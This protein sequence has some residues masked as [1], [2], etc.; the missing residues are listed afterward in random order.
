MCSS[1]IAVGPDGYKSMVRCG[2]CL[3]CR[4]RRKQSWVGRLVLERLEHVAARF[5]TLTYA[6]Q[7]QQASALQPAHAKLFLDLYR[8]HYGP[9]RYFLVGE[10]GEKS[11]HAHWHA[12]I[13]GHPQEFGTGLRNGGHW[14]NNKAW[15]RGYSFDGAVTLQSIGY[16]A[17]YT[18][19]EMARGR[20][21]ITR[22]S[23]KPGLGFNAIGRLARS[24]GRAALER[25]IEAWPAS[26]QVGGA[27][28]PLT[29]GALRHFQSEFSKAGGLPPAS[30]SP[31]DRHTVTMEA[32]AD[33][34]TL[35]STQRDANNQ[36]WNRVYRDG[37]TPKL[38][39]I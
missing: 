31:E 32:L 22:M 36:Y 34:G 15:D 16:V 5:V 13:F 6:D 28:Y 24:Y 3:P 35:L 25:P 10:Y 19:K 37:L 14:H 9:F 29:D 27:R 1:P 23:L 4:V 12:I 26:L 21:S 30:I 17:K 39:S 20:R 7:L 33:W 38:G 11:G 8:Y 2:R 18:T